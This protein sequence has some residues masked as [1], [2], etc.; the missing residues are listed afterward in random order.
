MQLDHIKID[1]I[2]AFPFDLFPVQQEVPISAN[3]PNPFVF[4]ST[5]QQEK[6]RTG[7]IPVRLI[8]PG[9]PFAMPERTFTLTQKGNTLTATTLPKDMWPTI[10][11][12]ITDNKGGGHTIV[13]SM[14]PAGNIIQGKILYSR[15]GYFLGKAKEILIEFPTI[16]KSFEWPIPFDE[17]SLKLWERSGIIARKIQYI[18]KFFG[19][20]FALPSKFENDDLV[21]VEILF[22]GI[23][24][25]KFFICTP[26]M[27]STWNPLIEA[28]GHPPFTGV[29]KFSSVFAG[30][31]MKLFGQQLRVGRVVTIQEQAMLNN[32]EI[33]E[34]IRK[35][36]THPA[37]LHLTLLDQK[38]TWQFEKF[39]KELDRDE[40][41]LSK[42]LEEYKTQL[43]TRYHEPYELVNLVH[44]SL[45]ENDPTDD[46]KVLAR[47][48]T[49]LKQM[50]EEK[51][52]IPNQREVT[53]YLFQ[54]QNLVELLPELCYK[55]RQKLGTDT[56][57]S[58]EVYQS[59]EELDEFL[60]LYVQPVKYYKG[61]MDEI[62]EVYSEYEVAISEQAGYLLVNIDY[63]RP[64]TGHGI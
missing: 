59:K 11:I 23:T 24:K 15:C 20:T 54:F 14:S 57:F 4:G 8:I 44:K 56:K 39:T 28:L 61:I 1:A 50:E 9:A 37:N 31:K 45:I 22:R 26:E 29:G 46:S 53:N 3:N 55:L 19:K 32:P 51:I 27:I 48:D 6:A 35:Y 18:E 13:F 41:A 36:P 62:D 40:K 30:D 2:S 38:M 7:T 12:Q 10:S 64:R 47:I 16:H 43:V 63:G 21:K 17:K 52:N 49:L 33:I 58:V 25:G 34:Q 5:K 42:K 60:T